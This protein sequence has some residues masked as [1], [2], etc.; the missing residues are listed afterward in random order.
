MSIGVFRRNRELRETVMTIRL[1]PSEDELI[2]SLKEELRFSSYRD[3]VMFGMDIINLLKELKANGDHFYAGDPLRR[4]YEEIT[5]EIYPMP[6]ETSVAVLED[7]RTG[8]GSPEPLI[9]EKK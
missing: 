7:S 8:E 9:D 2:K 4:K 1:T 5:L 3:L 6:V